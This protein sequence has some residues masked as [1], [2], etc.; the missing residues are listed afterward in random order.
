LDLKRNLNNY[1]SLAASR[2][3]GY[4]I[5]FKL[6]NNPSVVFIFAAILFQLVVYKCNLWLDKAYIENV[7]L[8]ICG[9]FLLLSFYLNTW[10]KED[11]SRNHLSIAIETLF[12]LAIVLVNYSYLVGKW[13]TP[14]REITSWYYA[15]MANFLPYN[16]AGGYCNSTLNLMNEGALTSWGLSVRSL[17]SYTFSSLFILTKSNIQTT[18]I[19]L[20]FLTSTS[21]FI[22]YRVIKESTSYL[23]GIV[24][25]MICVFQYVQYNGMFTG[26]NIGFMFSICSGYLLVQ[27]YFRNSKNY[28]YL[29][30]AAIALSF[31]LRAGA[32]FV[33]PL[34][35]L[36]LSFKFRKASHFLDY[37]FGFIGLAI[38]F[39]FSLSNKVYE[40]ISNPDTEVVVQANFSYILY[41]LSKG[42]VKAWKTVL[43]DH[44]ELLDLSV[45]ERPDR[46]Y[47]LAIESIKKEP[48]VVFYTLWNYLKH[49]NINSLSNMMTVRIPAAVAFSAKWY[50]LLSFIM[51]PLNLFLWKWSM[52]NWIVIAMVL[53]IWLSLPFLTV[54][55]SR[56]F[57]ATHIFANLIPVFLYGIVTDHF[58]RVKPALRS[59]TLYSL[60]NVTM[61]SICTIIPLIMVGYSKFKPAVIIDTSGYACDTELML[62]KMDNNYIEI[63]NEFDLRHHSIDYKVY[64]RNNPRWRVK[65][66]DNLHYMWDKSSR[67]GSYLVINNMKDYIPHKVAVLC[68]DSMAAITVSTGKE[69]STKLYQGEIIDI[70]DRKPGSRYHFGD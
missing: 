11:A 68:V 2:W 21:I 4:L 31:N 5:E 23:L 48:S 64:R 22:L 50:F 32:Y 18:L 13:S 59:L 51:I 42:K 58:K 25:A 26:E 53:G 70:L 30:I 45:D 60:N 20:S 56:V 44:P 28:I 24:T 9:I 3:Q 66:G 43:N 33:A 62:Y 29:A 36:V 52:N 1:I 6:G 14:A 65:R 61:F 16:D 40:K 8:L 38:F 19:L 35:I 12:F 34:I 41:S 39:L 54:G 10:K 63:S 15:T 69:P 57:A 46:I 47:N 17:I 67:W 27:G 55:G 37:K 7:F 49:H